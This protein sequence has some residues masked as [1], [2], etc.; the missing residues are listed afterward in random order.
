MRR[1]TIILVQLDK[2]RLMKAHNKGKKMKKIAYK[3]ILLLLI[4]S[5]VRFDETA[6]G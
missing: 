6:N 2:L 4:I 3:L 5:I 1:F